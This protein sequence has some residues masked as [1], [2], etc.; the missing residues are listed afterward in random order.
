M[1]DVSTGLIWLQ[2]IESLV[3]VV[4]YNIVQETKAQY[5]I[6]YVVVGE[7]CA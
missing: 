7:L 1:K 4:L 5:G 3:Y 2:G 6:A